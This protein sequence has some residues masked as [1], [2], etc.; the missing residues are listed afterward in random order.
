MPVATNLRLI[1]GMVGLVGFGYAMIVPS[2][3]GR[4]QAAALNLGFD[5]DLNTYIMISG[6]PFVICYLDRVTV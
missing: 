1:Q 4:A 5:N 2:S 6:K 3:F